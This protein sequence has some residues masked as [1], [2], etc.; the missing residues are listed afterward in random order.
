MTASAAPATKRLAFHPHRIVI[1]A[2]V[3]LMLGSMSLPYV[4]FD[5]G[6]RSGLALGAL[7]ALALVLPIFGFTMVPDHSRPLPRWSGM[8]SASL[9]LLA[10]PYALVTLLD[11]AVLADTLGGTI[12]V[13]AWALL[14][15]SLV[16]AAGVGLGFFLPTPSPLPVPGDRAER[17]ATTVDPDAG[18]APQPD[19]ADTR[20]I[21]RT[22]PSLDVSPF[23]EPLFDS[24]E[25]LFPPPPAIGAGGGEADGA[26]ASLGTP[27]PRP[28]GEPTAPAAPPEEPDDAPTLVFEADRAASRFA[29]DPDDH[30][31]TT[32]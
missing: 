3:L 16:V 18:P 20:P 9:T 21:R 5:D 32:G 15:G 24:L 25:I 28:E 31:H 26:D 27:G 4:S 29:D 17:P 1:D 30:H 14:V 22:A 10:A 2:G 11:A 23:G 19:A 12:G 8:V 6:S 13:G 7:P